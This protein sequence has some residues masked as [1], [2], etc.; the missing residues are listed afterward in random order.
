MPAPV[1][2]PSSP[3]A[4]VDGDA[5][6]GVRRGLAVRA[7]AR[8]SAAP[9]VIGI[10]KPRP[11]EPP[12]PAEPAGAGADRGVDADDLAGEVD[13]RAA[14][15]AGVDRGVGLDRGVGRVGR[16]CDR[17]GALARPTP[18]GSSELTM[19]LVTVASRPNGE[20]IATTSSPTSRASESPISAGGQ[21]GDVLGLDHREVGDRVGADDGRRSAVVPSL[22]LTV[23]RPP[24]PA[25]ST[26]WLLVR[27][28]PSALRMMPEPEP[29][30]SCAGDVD[31]HDRGQDRCG[32]RLDRARRGR[33]VVELESSDAERAVVSGA[34]GR[35]WCSR[36]R[37]AASYPAAPATPPRRR[38]GAAAASQRCRCGGG[39]RPACACA[40]AVA[41][42]SRRG[43]RWV[44]AYGRER[45]WSARG[46]RTGGCGPPLMA[47]RVP[48]RC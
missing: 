22:K 27:I 1:T 45:R 25:T 5:E 14:G 32:D 38:R 4:R 26:T 29:W 34:P 28:S 43:R 42:W 39:P 9:C 36:R 21:P 40:G 46:R 13:Q 47:P 18:G 3:V 44:R 35:R 30:P 37:R 16:R 24:S 20:P 2:S 15:V 17:S 33:G 10:A 8:R 31:L 23:S 11:I 48:A 12:S 19:P 7:A 41:R 6:P